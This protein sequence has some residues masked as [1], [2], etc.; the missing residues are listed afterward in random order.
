[1]PLIPLEDNFSDIINK[2]QNGRKITDERLAS[3]AGVSLEDLALVKGGKVNVAVLRR[4]ARHLRLNPD[5][6]EAIAKRTWYPK[7]P[8]IARGFAMF[9]NPHGE[10]S[11]NSYLVWDLRS[12]LAAAIDTGTDSTDMI[13]FVKSEGLRLQYVFL[14]HAHEDHIGGLPALLAA[15]KAE[16]WIHE[17]EPIPHP[18]TRQFKENAYFH[19]GEVAIKALLTKGHS[20]GLTTFFTTGNGLPI[21]FVGDAL[22]AGSMGGSAEH[23][24]LQRKSNH[25]KILS[26]PKDSVL[27][28]GHGPLTTLA[29]ERE[30]NPFIA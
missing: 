30:H 9:N 17:A 23:F 16:A 5:A 27:A 22:F 29:Q 26:L 15:T 4:V 25:D 21:A 7:V 8:I 13:D 3:V 12:K 28:P 6:L 24:E 1:M 20:P 14:T 11:V 19:I 2:A 10:T 18:G